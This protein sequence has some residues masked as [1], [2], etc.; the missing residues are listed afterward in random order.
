MKILHL[1]CFLIFSITA[2]SQTVY[3]TPSGVKYHLA[4]CRMVTNVSQAISISKALEMGLTPCKICK[5]PM[6]QKA[7]NFVQKSTKG[8]SNTVQCKAKT[9]A[10]AR[11]KR[12]TSIGNGFCFQHNPDK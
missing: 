3:K 11:F 4:S 12:R 2:Q 1:L 9:K 5:P 6:V 7:N 8:E 10:G